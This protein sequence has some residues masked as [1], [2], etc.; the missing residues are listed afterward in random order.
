MV[1][2]ADGDVGSRG[3]QRFAVAVG[4]VQ[5]LQLEE[6]ETRVSVLEMVTWQALIGQFSE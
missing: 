4:A 1:V 3:G 6:M 2:L 5:V